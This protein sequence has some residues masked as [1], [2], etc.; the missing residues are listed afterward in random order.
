MSAVQGGL[1]LATFTLLVLGLAA[2]GNH[3]TAQAG[4]AAQVASTPIDAL[5]ADPDGTP[6]A[7]AGDDAYADE[8]LA[9]VPP[10][11]YI[12]TYAEVQRESD[13]VLRRMIAADELLADL[14]RID[15]DAYDLTR[16]D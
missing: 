6:A 1:V 2:Y 11:V 15:F 5:L 10:V 3:R 14:S 12:P 16:E 4:R 9:L 7:P 13:A 8:A